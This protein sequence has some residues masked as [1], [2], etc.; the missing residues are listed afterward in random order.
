MLDTISKI[1]LLSYRPTLA[2]PLCRTRQKFTISTRSSA[3]THLLFVA[4]DRILPPSTMSL[5]RVS[6]TKERFYPAFSL[7]VSTTSAA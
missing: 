6:R 4:T 2:T 7:L 1:L 3:P 5:Q